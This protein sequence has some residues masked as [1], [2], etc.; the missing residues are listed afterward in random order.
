MFNP[1]TGQFETRRIATMNPVVYKELTDNTAAVSEEAA[2]LREH[3]AK[4]KQHLRDIKTRLRQLEQAKPEL[5][6][7]MEL[8]S[9]HAKLEELE[10]RTSNSCTCAPT[11]TSKME[12]QISALQDKESVVV[13]SAKD[14]EL[15]ESV[16]ELFDAFDTAESAQIKINAEQTKKMELLDKKLHLSIWIS[17]ASTVLLI[18]LKLLL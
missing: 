7:A 6:V 12:A 8:D 16:S 17:V 13:I 10:A 1:L 3:S 9:I 11:D 18:A 14:D 15:A 5:D 2:F 4:N